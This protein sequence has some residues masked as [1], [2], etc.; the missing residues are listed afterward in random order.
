MCGLSFFAVKRD[1]PALRDQLQASLAATKHRGPDA[2]GTYFAEIANHQVGLG[3]NRLSILDLSATGSQPMFTGNGISIVFN[4]EIFNHHELRNQLIEQGYTF[5]GTSDTE[6]IL[7]LYVAHGDHAFKRLQGMYTFVILDEPRQKTFLVRDVIGIKPVYCYTGEYG[8]YACSEIRG[9]KCYSDVVTE[10]DNDDVFEFF[11]NGFLYEPNTGYKAIKKLMPGTYLEFDLLTGD[12][13]TR[14]HQTITSYTSEQSLAENVRSAVT[15]Q[16]EADV[17]VGVFFSGGADSSILASFTGEADLFFAKYEATDDSVIDMRFSAE[18]ADYLHKKLV[19]TEI[20]DSKDDVFESIDFVAANTEELVSDY[21]FWA[22]YRLSAE[23]RKSG[24]TVMLSG[25]GGDEAFAGYPRY[26]VLKHHRL[27]RLLYPV[28][29][30]LLKLKLFPKQLDK[31]FER[32]VS[33]AEESYW[34]LAYS[35]MLGYFSRQELKGFFRDFAGLECHYKQR[36]NAVLLDYSGDP[37]DKVKFAQHFDLTGFLSH[38]LSVSDKASM[39]ASI[40]LRV[41]L[42]D[43][44]IVAKGLATSSADLLKGGNP[45]APLKTLLKSLLP[46]SL[47]DRPKTGF[48]PPLDGIIRRIGSERLLSEFE[49]IYAYLRPEEVEKLVKNHFMGTANNT[50][51]LWQ[52]LY[53]ERWLKHNFP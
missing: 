16:L 42:L 1:T 17:P 7:Q 37:A 48:N 10:I 31:K 4:G 18:I 5:N 25:M 24:Y 19:V 46:A 2:S 43:E 50:Y 53:F 30:A 45:K 21:T 41:P 29:N 14:R 38:N 8:I 22:T 9:L 15:R 49:R 28:L 12:C 44:R 26:K 27:I 13:R 6:V 52:V 40:E 33:Y 20:L 32:L 23:A 36:L 34:P 51:K 11:N 47:V 3:H 39:L 35:R